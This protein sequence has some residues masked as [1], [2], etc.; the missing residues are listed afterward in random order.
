MI[1]PFIPVLVYIQFGAEWPGIVNLFGP[2]IN[3]AAGKPVKRSTVGIAFN[4][5]LLYF[6]AHILHY[7]PQVPEYREVTFDRMTLLKQVINT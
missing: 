1:K 7:K 3:H 6:G 4:K 2:L 5:I